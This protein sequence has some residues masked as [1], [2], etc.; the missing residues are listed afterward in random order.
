MKQTASID[1]NVTGVAEVVQL[2]RAAR[3]AVDHATTARPDSDLD[4]GVLL[5]ARD[6]AVLRAAIDPILPGLPPGA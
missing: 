5:P 2:A 1:V 6:L 3:D 4:G